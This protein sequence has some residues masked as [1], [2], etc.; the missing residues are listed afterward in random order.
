MVRWNM[1]NTLKTQDHRTRS[2]IITHETCL[3]PLKLKIHLR[4][5]RTQSIVSSLPR[6]RYPVHRGELAVPEEEACRTRTGD[7]L[8]RTS[9][10]SKHIL[11]KQ[12]RLYTPDRSTT[13]MQEEREHLTIQLSMPLVIGYI[14]I[15][16]SI[17]SLHDTILTPILHTRSRSYD[18]LSPTRTKRTQVQQ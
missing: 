5:K 14:A 4:Q 9:C 16:N 8:N 1:S 3:P 7:H 6:L 12:H 11:H 13:N 15:S 10:G 18:A 17:S 2:A